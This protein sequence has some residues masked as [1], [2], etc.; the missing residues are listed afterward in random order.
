MLWRPTAC[1]EHTIRN[2]TAGGGFRNISPPRQEEYDEEESFRTVHRNVP[3]LRDA[4]RLWPHRFQLDDHGRFDDGAKDTLIVAIPE[5]PTYMDPMVQASIGTYRVTT[6]MFDR[7]VMMDNDMNL[8]PGLA[9]SWEVIDDT[10][11]VFHLRQGV[12]FHNGEEMTSEDVKYSLERCIANPGVNYNYLI[13]ES[14]TCDDDYTVTI[15]TSAPFNALLYRLSLDAA[16]IICKSADTSAEEFNKNP[17][18]TGPF[19]FVSWELGGDVVLEAFEDYWGGA[20]AVK[21]VIFRTIPEALNR[22]IGLETGEVDLAYDLGITDLESLADNASVTTLTSPS[23]TV[24][25]V[26]MNV[27]KA[28]FD[29]EK[30]RQAVAYA[31]DPQGYIDLVFSGEATP[32]NYTMLP[33]SVDGYVSDCSDYSCNVEKAKELLAEAGYPD[34][35]STT[36][37]CS[38]TQV[39]RDSAVVIQEQLRQVGINAEVKTLESG[40]F[41]SETGNGAHDMFIMSKT[42]IDPDSMLRSMYHTEA[43]GPSGNRCFWT[44]PEVDALIDEASTTTDTEHAMEL[45][46]EI[47][48]KVAEAAPLV[49]MAVE[50]LN[51]GM[52]SNVKGFGLYPGKSHYINGTYFE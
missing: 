8:V 40:Q 16:S 46:A 4:G 47:Q 30:V 42:S 15:K 20:P 26:G 17:V 52:Q 51:A 6:Q 33:P 24:W 37:W 28:P 10:T 34:G 11:T 12:K 23:T 1:A 7:L 38:D 5:S 50:H 3:A 44:T 32:A 18:G 39:M 48:S 22:T 19:K 29:N 35:F 41:Q 21:R 9:E 36:L 31:L 43:L 14:I 2:V 45:Y 49:P 13:I 27:Q 25:Y